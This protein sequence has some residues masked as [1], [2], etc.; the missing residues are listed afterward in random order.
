MFKTLDMLKTPKVLK[1]LEILDRSIISNLSK[2]Y[3]ILIVISNKVR[4]D[5]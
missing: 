1:M 5:I 3:K 4:R 2:M